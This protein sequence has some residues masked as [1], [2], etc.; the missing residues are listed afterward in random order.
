MADGSSMA[1][2]VP[3][4]LLPAG[5]MADLRHL[6]YSE[7][8]RCWTVRCGGC[9]EDLPCDTEFYDLDGRGPAGH[10]KACKSERNPA[11]QRNHKRAQR[12]ALNAN[13]TEVAHG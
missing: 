7:D 2:H 4:M 11:W 1:R 5:R 9:G 13:A 6:Q 12:N 8:M 3:K 10:C